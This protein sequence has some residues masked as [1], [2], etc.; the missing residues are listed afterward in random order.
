[1]KENIE[2]AKNLER[3][4]LDGLME[5][6]IKDNFMK[7]IFMAKDVILGMTKESTQEIGNLI[8]WMEKEYLN[9]LMDVNIKDNTKTIRKMDMVY[10]NG[11][12]K[13]F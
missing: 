2:Q 8:K 9:G 3:A 11:K 1:M 7:I 5:V 10:S 12:N 4:N 6:N 13:L